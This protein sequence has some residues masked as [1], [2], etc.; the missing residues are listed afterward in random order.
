MKSRISLT[1]LALAL[2]A[3]LS[4]CKQEEEGA[5]EKAGKQMDE[6]MEKVEKSATE[7]YESAKEATEEAMHDAGEA[8]AEVEQ[9]V[10]EAMDE[11]GDA[12][13]DMGQD[14]EQAAEEAMDQLSIGTGDESDVGPL[15]DPRQPDIIDRQVADA[16]AGG[17]AIA[18][19]GRRALRA[20]PR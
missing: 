14:M 6:T 13:S 3:S 12:M 20:P 5:M 4:A 7:T 2:V 17:A 10:G 18:L 15:I 9:D 11:A 1:A 16:V 19:R 8:M